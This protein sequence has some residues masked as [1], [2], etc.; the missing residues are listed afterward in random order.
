MASKRYDR[1]YFILGFICGFLLA[2]LVCFP[3]HAADLSTDPMDA[4]ESS[5][6]IEIQPEEP[7]P[8]PPPDDSV[9]YDD[10]DVIMSEP[11]PVEPDP[12]TDSYNESQDIVVNRQDLE[13]VIALL[14]D[15]SKQLSLYASDTSGREPTEEDL[16]YRENLLLTLSGI[17]DSLIVLTEP[18]AEEPMEEEPAEEPAE[19][20]AEEDTSAPSDTS[21]PADASAL[22]ETDPADN[23]TAPADAS[24]DASMVDDSISEQDFYKLVLALLLVLVFVPFISWAY[25]FISS[26]FPV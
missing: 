23:D 19:E 14:N 17:H 22:A 18:P 16:T 2:A 5:A 8:E 3:A 11:D 12:Y 10:D 6:P 1:L 24:A 4:G 26:F 9:I 15:L 7:E 21:A 20:Q 25:K 13:D